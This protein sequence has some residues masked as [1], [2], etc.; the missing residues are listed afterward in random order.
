MGAL[1]ACTHPSSVLWCYGRVV[2][3]LG[4]RVQG[5]SGIHM[6]SGTTVM[7]GG[8]SWQ[9]GENYTATIGIVI[10]AARLAMQPTLH[11]YQVVLTLTAPAKELNKETDRVQGVY[12]GEG[13]LRSSYFRLLPW[14]AVLTSLRRL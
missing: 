3:S 4:K 10:C 5:S 6:T 13:H 11:S 8:D 7:I 12:F 9:H 1:P 14:Q 2:R